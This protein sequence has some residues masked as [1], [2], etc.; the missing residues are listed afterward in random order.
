MSLG[1]NEWMDEVKKLS[2]V[3]LRVMNIAITAL[4]TWNTFREQFGWMGLEVIKQLIINE[5]NKE[6]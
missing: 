4:L 3:E 5:E 2:R 1:I 6:K